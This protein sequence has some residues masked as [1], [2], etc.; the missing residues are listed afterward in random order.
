MDEITMGNF[1]AGVILCIIC[2]I[3]GMTYGGHRG[4]DNGYS[5]GCVSGS[6]GK[7]DVIEINGNKKCMPREE[8]VKLKK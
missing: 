2:F 3:F 4:Y 5:L 6:L 8:I 7:F 1:I